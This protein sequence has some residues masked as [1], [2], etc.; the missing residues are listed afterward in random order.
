MKNNTGLTN[1]SY[2]NVLSENASL[3]QVLWFFTNQIFF[4]NY[5]FPVYWIKRLILRIYGAKIGKDV[6]INP[7]VYIKSPWL[8]EIGDNVWIGEKVWIENAAHVKIHSN[9]CVSQSALLISGDHNYS[10]TDF[11]MTV[12]RVTLE[13]GVWI[14]ANSKIGPGVTCRSHSMLKRDSIAT[15]D[16]EE[17]C[18]YQGTPASIKRDRII[19]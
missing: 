10:Q 6:Y 9:S 17:F 12:S 14:G 3:R 2:Q 4:Y 18:K 5:F 8:L 11:D 13:T 15:D 19:R 7:M 1:F 16:L